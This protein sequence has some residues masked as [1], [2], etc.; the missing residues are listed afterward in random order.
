MFDFFL[1]TRE[2]MIA[3]LQASLRSVRQL[4]N[5][6]AQ[7]LGDFIGVTRQTVNNLETGKTPMSPT[8]YVA[9]SAVLDKVL[10]EK[11]ELYPALTSVIQT[12]GYSAED[13]LGGE[14]INVHNGSFLKKW[15]MCFPGTGSLEQTLQGKPLL[16]GDA[17]NT[18]AKNYKIFVN[19]DSL[20]A[21]SSQEFFDQFA[22]LL[23]QHGNRLI[24]PL[25]VVETLQNM[26]LVP[27][28]L[29]AGQAKEGLALLTDLQARE[30]IEIRGEQ[31]DKT[32]N[33]LLFSVFARHKSSYRLLLIT[34]TEN[35]A[36][37]ILSLN[38]NQSLPGFSIVCCYLDGEG[39]LKVY[40]EKDGNPGGDIQYLKD[41][42]Y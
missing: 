33:S 25:L 42:T 30:V 7:E 28:P 12:S 16:D 1:H 39:S 3:N 40:N 9:I 11:P 29:K 35:L 15:F 6:S 38:H 26:L 18:I 22:P 27:D 5:L 31:T 23:K 20:L 13:T 34:Q 24:I 17:L 41:T 19:Y 32:I 36:Q 4:L 10:E 21:Q 14:I 2:K 37:D 8:Q